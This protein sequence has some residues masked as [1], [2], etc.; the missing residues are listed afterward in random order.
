MNDTT[1]K[2]PPTQEIKKLVC[3][4]AC[5]KYSGISASIHTQ[6]RFHDKYIK[7]YSI[8]VNKYKDFDFISNTFN[9]N[10]EKAADNWWKTRIA[11]GPGVDW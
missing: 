5:M 2:Q 1:I 3:A 7:I 6:Q 10:I 11:S 9:Q 8:M 4:F